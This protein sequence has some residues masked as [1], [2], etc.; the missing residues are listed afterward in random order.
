MGHESGQTPKPIDD[1]VQ[2]ILAQGRINL[3]QPFITSYHGENKGKTTGNRNHE[4]DKPLPNV[5]TSNRFAIVDPFFL[6]NEGFYRGNQPR[7]LDKPLSTITASRGAGKLV[8][9]FVF[10]IGQTAAKDRSRSIDAPLSTIVTKQ[11]HCLVEAGM[12]LDIRF[13]MLKNHELKQG[14][15]FSKDFIITG[16]TTEQTRQIGNAVPP[17]LARALSKVAMKQKRQRKGGMYV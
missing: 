6:P 17:G 10:N 1:P 8:E 12:Y 4:I 16:N 13:R 5:D 14:Q 11:E 2:T 3:I 15:G 7:S 9:P